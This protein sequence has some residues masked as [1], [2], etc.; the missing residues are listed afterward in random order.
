[1][2][3]RPM[4]YR[5]DGKQAVPTDLEDAERV[6]RGN[7]HVGDTTIGDTRVSTVFLGVDHA[8][9][10]PPVLFETMCFGGS[11]DGDQERYSTWDEAESGHK[12]WVE[13]VTTEEGER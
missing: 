11:Y 9:S 10:G 5:L 4:L 7:R 6:F 3:E 2:K 1:M 12:R 8:I 13:R